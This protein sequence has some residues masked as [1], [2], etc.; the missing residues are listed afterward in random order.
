MNSSGGKTPSTARPSA[1][2]ANA[3]KMIRNE[4]SQFAN[5]GDSS[6]GQQSPQPPP[7]QQQQVDSQYH[8]VLRQ[9]ITNGFILQQTSERDVLCIRQMLNQV[10]FDVSIRFFSFATINYS[11]PSI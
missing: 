3:M 7:N 9:Q 2:N 1:Y 11:N 8:D 5:S 10:G 4:L 6:T